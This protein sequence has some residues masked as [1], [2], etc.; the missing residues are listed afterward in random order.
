MKTGAWGLKV[1]TREVVA[2][3][4][5][6]GS[7]L[8]PSFDWL[9]NVTFLGA[10]EPQTLILDPSTAWTTALRYDGTLIGLGLAA[11]A[12]ATVVFCR[13]DLWRLVPGFFRG[14]G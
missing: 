10:Y 12:T 2:R 8:V 3:S 1:T 9:M 4:R 13:R 5:Q 11:Y 14:R 6:A 7:P